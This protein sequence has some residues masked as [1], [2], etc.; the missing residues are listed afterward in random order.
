VL[1]GSGALGVLSSAAEVASGESLLRGH[2][3]GLL[4][5]LVDVVVRWYRFYSKRRTC[6]LGMVVIGDKRPLCSGEAQVWEVS[7]E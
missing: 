1:A 6:R 3:D 5:W 2:V 7:I 4:G